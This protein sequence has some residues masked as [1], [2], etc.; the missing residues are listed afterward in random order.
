M[1]VVIMTIPIPTTTAI[2][3]IPT[4]VTLMS[5]ASIMTGV[6]I[7]TVGINSPIA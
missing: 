4:T 2:T 7:T 1:T 5:L 6:N 3:D